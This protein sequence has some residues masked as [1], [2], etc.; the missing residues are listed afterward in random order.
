MT[1]SITLV[2]VLLT[3][4]A[5]IGAFSRDKIMN[6][7]VFYG[8]AI[9]NNGQ[10]Y[11]FISSGFVHANYAHLIFNMLALYSFGQLLEKQLY[12]HDCYLGS[13]GKLFFVVLYVL[14]LVVSS[15]PDYI[16]HKDND[17]YRSLGASGAVSAVMFACIVLVPKAGIGFPFLPSIEIPGYLF[18]LI[19]LIITAYLDKRGGGNIDH[20]AHLWGALFGILFTIV[21]VGLLGKVNLWDN[22]VNQLKASEPFLPYCGG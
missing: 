4:A 5:S 7:L 8:P 1:L 21:A 17:Y 22:F 18:G 16:K 9:K 12:S 2:I 15:I 6:D 19:Y 3:V 13:L 14:G 10:Y 20:G 11:R